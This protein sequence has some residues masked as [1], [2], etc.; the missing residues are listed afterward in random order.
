MTF[1]DYM[2]A[3]LYADDG[4]YAAY[5]PI[6]KAGDFYTAVST[7]RFF[8]GTIARHLIGQIESGALSAHCTVCEIGAHHGYLLADMIEFIHTLKPALLQTLTFVIVERFEH[9][10]AQQQRYFK[11]SF[12]DVITL[13]HYPSLEAM[14]VDEAFFVAN[15]IFDAFPCELFYQGKTARVQAHEVIFDQEDAWVS[16]RA[17]AF[18][19]DRGEIAVGY[20]AFAE[21][22]AR[23]ARKLEFVTFDYGE[24]QARPDVS[25]R[26]YQNHEVLPFFDETL[27]RAH[28]FKRSDITYDVTF[29]HVKAAF[30]EAG[31]PMIA[32][33]PQMKALVEMGI[34]DLLEMV[35]TH[36]G[37][38]VYRQE[39]EKVKPLILPEF[40]GE[41]FKMMRLGR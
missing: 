3:W 25:L 18:H 29:A 2:Q 10:R 34:L 41:R 32:F 14:Q 19:K 39:L 31:L 36:A 13:Q 20:E 40:M 5:R 16:A 35:K 4:Y 37:D 26:V 15:E 9:L 17:A 22:M 27:D 23:A 8:G 12:G 38:A 28:A 24:M 33:A 1:S 11:D 6:G 21:A 7:S 30:E